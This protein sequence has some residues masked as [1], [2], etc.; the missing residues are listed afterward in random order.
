MTLSGKVVEICKENS[1][2]VLDIG[3]TILTIDRILD[4]IEEGEEYTFSNC[5][6]VTNRLYTSKEVSK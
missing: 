2:I 5:L 4:Y 3:I 6:K 1:T